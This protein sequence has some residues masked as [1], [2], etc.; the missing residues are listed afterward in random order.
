MYEMPPLS[1]GSDVDGT[2]RGRCSTQTSRPSSRGSELVYG[3]DYEDDEERERKR[4][5][6]SELY[7]YVLAMRLRER[8]MDV[9]QVLNLYR[10]FDQAS[11]CEF[12]P[13]FS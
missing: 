12:Y 2:V 13:L 1:Y 5:L 6:G 10:D 9:R 4:F 7:G 3:G 8:L 11:G